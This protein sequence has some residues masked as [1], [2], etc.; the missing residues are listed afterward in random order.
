MKT[1]LIEHNITTSAGFYGSRT[2]FYN[3]WVTL[4]DSYGTDTLYKMNSSRGIHIGVSGAWVH[5]K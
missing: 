2:G 1:L 3:I 5:I 4:I